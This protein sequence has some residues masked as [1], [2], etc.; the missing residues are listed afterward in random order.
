LVSG[1]RRALGIVATVWLIVRL[2][3]LVVTPA[4]IWLLGDDACQCADGA[5]AACPMHHPAAPGRGTCAMRAA[6]AVHDVVLTSL[7]GASGCFFAA[8]AVPADWPV[9]SDTRPNAT[10]LISR[11][12]R[13]DPLPPWA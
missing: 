9:T 5:G 1:L 3:T 2:A 10:N 12:V 6:A 11:F 13:P 7:L 4:E 8:L